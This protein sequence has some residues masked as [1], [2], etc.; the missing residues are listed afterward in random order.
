MSDS[1]DNPQQRGLPS[2]G[3]LPPQCGLT[4]DS[5]ESYWGALAHGSSAVWRN[6]WVTAGFVT[7]LSILIYTTS[8]R[9][10]EFNQLN[11]RLDRRE[12]V[13]SVQYDGQPLARGKIAFRCQV[14][15]SDQEFTD[16]E[17]TIV[18]GVFRIPRHQGPVPGLYLIEVTSD[19]GRG[20]INPFVPRI[21]MYTDPESPVIRAHISQRILVNVD[22]SG[23]NRYNLRLH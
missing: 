20:E 12:L 23:V 9:L 17:G 2:A 13:G 10:Q 22:A 11:D 15:S 7:L 14:V 18:N 3:G 1:G 8:Q 4:P 16:A 19:A 21:E 5:G 6:L